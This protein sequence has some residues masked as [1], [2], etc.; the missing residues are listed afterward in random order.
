VAIECTG[1][2]SA[3]DLVL[4]TTKAGGRVVMSGIPA[5]G[6]D[7]T[8]L[9]FR[10]LEVAGAYTA[11]VERI[12]ETPRRTFDLAIEMATGLPILEELVGATYS[13]DRWREAIDHALGGAERER[14][15]AHL[16]RALTERRAVR[17]T[18][19]AYLTAA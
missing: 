10:E 16:E 17:R 12:G 2:R 5:P 1:S 3:L 6:A 14:F 4:R 7:L 8:P 9:W 11:G 15:L 13:L 18:A 19:V